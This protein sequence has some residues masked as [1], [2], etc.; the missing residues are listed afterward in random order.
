MTSELTSNITNQLKDLMRGRSAAS[1]WRERRHLLDTRDL[2]KEELDLFIE[3]AA[4]F[5]RAHEHEPPL[6]LLTGITVANIFYENSTRTRSSFEIAARRLGADVINLDTK[7]S[8]VTKGE[9]IVDT[10]RQL[11]SMRVGAVVQRHSAAGSAHL[12]ARELGRSVQVINAGDGWHAHPTQGLL[13][14]FTMTEVRPNL[15]GA[16]VAIIGD[17]THSRVA[18]SNIWLLKTRGAHVHVAGPPTLIPPAMEQM[19]V[20]VHQ[21]LEPAIENADFIIMLRLQLERQAQGLVPSIGE[22]RRLYRLDHTRLKIAQAS[23]K[24]LHPGPVNRGIE[25]TDELVD[26]PYYS[27]IT[28]QITNGV[29][30]RMAALYLL[31]ADQ[32]I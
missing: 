31:M 18:R 25:L 3:T 32:A 12:V 13:D 22:Y 6:T 26:D 30:T 29:A 15:E 16:K 20:T 19:G 21:Q 10:A 2:T 23:V 1:A 24:V 9:T 27:L 5:K 7:A 28:T 11:V 17:I 14:L 8:S 4:L